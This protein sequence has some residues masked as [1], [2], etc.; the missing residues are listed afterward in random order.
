MPAKLTELTLIFRRER[1]RFDG[2][3]TC[4]LECEEPSRNGEAGADPIIQPATG[5]VVGTRQELADFFHD[6][7]VI[8]KANV[9]DGELVGGLSYRFYGHWVE[10]DKYGRQF[11]AKTFVRCQPHG[12][13][14]V[15]LAT[16]ALSG[17][18]ILNDPQGNVVAMLPGPE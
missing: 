8:V 4:I 1:V 9:P 12:K 16:T 11:A 3:D 18:I 6:R 14:G 15:I 10:H 5:K 13:A 17:G 7:G 2:G